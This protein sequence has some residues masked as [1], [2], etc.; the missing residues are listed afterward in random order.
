VV[1]A[2]DHDRGEAAVDAG[3]ADL[4]ICA[5]VKVKRE[6][7][8]AV[9]SRSLG[10]S[11]EVSV[12]CILARTC[13][14]LKDHGRLLLSSRLGDRL[15]DLHVVDVERTNGILALVCLFEHF[16]CCYKCHFFTFLS[17]DAEP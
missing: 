2:V 15:N 1:R 4:E 6:V 17:A 9:L 12:L 10:Q 11:H 3:L 5:V 16:L 7:N 8:A 14:D 13:G